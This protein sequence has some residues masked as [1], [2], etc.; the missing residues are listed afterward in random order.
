MASSPCRSSNASDK[1]TVVDFLVTGTAGDGSDFVAI[2]SSVTILAGE[3]SAE[4]NVSVIDSDLL[5]DNETVIVTLTG[6]NDTDV[7]LDNSKKSATVTIADDDTATASITA[8]DPNAGEPSDNGEFTITLSEASDKATVV[9]FAVT[10]T[11]SAGSDYTTIA[12]SVTFVAGQTTATINVNVVASDLLEE[13]ETVIVTLTGTDDDDITVASTGNTATVT[14]TDPGTALLSITANDSTASEPSDDGQFTVTLSEAADQ[15]TVV[16][17]V[18]T[19]TANGGT[20]FIAL[21]GTVTIAAGSTDALIDVSVIDDLVLEDS[22]D[23]TV[24]LTTITSGDSDITIDG[25]AKSASVTITDTDVATA[26]ITANDLSAGEPGNDGQFTVTISNASDKDTTISFVITG[27]ADEGDDF[28]ALSGTVTILAGETS[29]AIDV[30]VVDDLLLEENETV[31]VTLTGTSDSDV[32]LDT[33]S[34]SA[35]ITIT[36]DDTASVSIA[37]SDADATEPGDP[38][39]NG[40]FTVTMTNASTTDTVL[41]L[42]ITGTAGAGDDYVAIPAT[43]TI[44]AGQ[45][46]ATIDVSVI[47]SDLLEDSETVIVTLTSIA[48]SDSDVSIDTDANSAAV[49]IA[50]DDAATVSI[51]A[52]DAAAAE[53]NENGQFTVTLSEASDKD[54]VLTYT[55]S[56]DATADTDYIALSGTVTH[57][58]GPKNGDDRC[59]GD[60][61]G[62][63]GRQ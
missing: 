18:V 16:K 58:S 21:S 55:V 54:T 5:E 4:I 52:T 25:D 53:P 59:H 28:T 56:G 2:G 49:T 10:G 39:D 60:R 19:G 6:T 41:N 11:A 31:I 29:A 32:T 34:K 44:V 45:T 35:T 24:T 37:A 43:V 12:S 15:D 61:S 63:A 47:D 36:D 22:E 3:T 62:I 38:S 57:R 23:V 9:N 50:D 40:Q 1:D 14:I 46:T 42:V 48:S 51:A 20:D 13:S 26:S 27:T 8:T 17:Y 7:T 30:A 33:D